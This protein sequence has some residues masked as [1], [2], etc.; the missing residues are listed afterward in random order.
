MLSYNIQCDAPNY[1][2]RL[3]KIIDFLKKENADIIALQEVKYGSYTKIISELKDQNFF[4]Y[5]SNKVQFNRIYGELLLTKYKITSSEYIRYDTSP[6]IRGL[7]KYYLNQNTLV[8]TTHLDNICKYNEKQIKIIQNELDN[9]PFE[10]NVILLGDFNFFD[11][12]CDKFNLKDAGKDFGNTY[13]S[14]KYRSRPD[15]IYYSGFKLL[16]FKIY[17]T[18]ESDHKSIIGEFL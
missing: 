8:I 18:G 3:D 12:N 7:T 17:D 13:I 5:L 14:E 16:S 2:K 9:K 1:L 15:R 10:S 4:Y 6:N 11:E